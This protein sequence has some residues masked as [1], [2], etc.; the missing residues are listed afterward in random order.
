[1]S[2]VMTL[3]AAS[4]LVMLPQLGLAQHTHHRDN[5]RT[6]LAQASAYAELTNPIGRPVSTS[7]SA[8]PTTR[9]HHP[10]TLDRR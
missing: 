1:M 4:T 9:R 7:E 10:N 6:A 3:A 5:D 2:R 8:T